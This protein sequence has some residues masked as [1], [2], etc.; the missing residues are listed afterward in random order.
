MEHVPGTVA[1]DAD[2]GWEAHHGEAAADSKARFYRTMAS[3]QVSPRLQSVVI[4]SL[5]F[6]F[7]GSK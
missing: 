4:P 6:L 2:G 3:I 1:M 7:S 5:M